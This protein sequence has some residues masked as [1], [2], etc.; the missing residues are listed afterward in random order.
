MSILHPSRSLRFGV[1][2][3]PS[4][5]ADGGAGFVDCF[6]VAV[7]TSSWSRPAAQGSMAAA[8]TGHVDTRRS[9]GSFPLGRPSSNV[10]Q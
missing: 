4:Q 8:G 1:S 9:F 6:A 2:N 10:E 3:S 5:E 7:N